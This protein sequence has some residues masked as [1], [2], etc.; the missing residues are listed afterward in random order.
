MRPPKPSASKTARGVFVLTACGAVL[1]TLAVQR[2]DPSFLR[3][4]IPVLLLAVAIYALLKPR[5]GSE[6]LNPRMSRGWFDVTFGLSI[7]FYDGF[8]GPGTGTFWT[9]AFMLCLGF[10]LTR[11]T[12]Y[13]KVVNFASNLSSLAFFAFRGNV[14]YAA[15]L[16]MGVGQLLGARI[17]SRMVIA[18]GTRF[19]RPVFIS[20]VLA[21]TLKLVW[22]QY[23]R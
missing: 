21:L 4:A 7:G 23:R 10:N 9:M 13:S 5:L 14:L 15:G 16:T 2:L 12:A 17:G 18:K 3:R 22:D 20:V 6:D 8:F 11:A 19:I 1:G